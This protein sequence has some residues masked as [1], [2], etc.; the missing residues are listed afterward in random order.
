V[1]DY[2]W[3][4]PNSVVRSYLRDGA[5]GWRLD[6]AYELGLPYLREMTDAAHR[7]KPGSLVVGEIVNYP[8]AWLK[9]MDSVMNFTLRDLVLGLAKGEIEPATATRMLNRLVQDAGIE[10]LLKSWVVIDNHDITRIATQFPETAQRRLVQ[11]LQFTLPGA[12]NIYYGAEVGM[13]GGGDPEN[14]GPMRWD[15][16]KADNPELVWMKQLIGLRKQHR[17]LRVGDYHPVE[18]QRLFAFERRTDRTLDTRIVV[19]NPSNQTVRERLLVSNAFLMD[20]TPM[21]DVLG[22]VPKPAAMGFGPGFITVEVP[23]QGVLVLQPQPKKLGGY[24]R[25]KRVP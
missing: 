22:L 6:T 9:S 17:A 10:P 4:A 19:V 1:R 2:L 3:N 7:E 8:A 12:P 18:A 23:P 21:V 25:Y 5:D 11:A 15:L 20:D 16:V 24:T 14:R 13:V